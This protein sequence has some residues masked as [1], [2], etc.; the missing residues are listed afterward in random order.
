[1]EK[2]LNSKNPLY[3]LYF[4]DGEVDEGENGLIWKDILKEGEWAYRPVGGKA[5]P[6]PL[7]VVA[8][9]ASD[10]EI[11]FSDVIAAFEDEAIQHV[12]I[13]T[14]HSDLPHENTGYVRKLRLKERNGVKFLQ[15]ALEFTEPEIKEKAL[16]GSIANTSSGLLFD[17]VK[18][19]TGKKYKIAL[20]HVAL[21]NKPWLN[22][23]QPF[24]V[25]A[26]ENFS[27]EDHETL[28]LENVIWDSAKSLTS[29]RDKVQSTINKERKEN[30]PYVYVA[31]ITQNKA[32][33]SDELSRN[34]YVVSFQIRKDGVKVQE[35]TKWTKASKEWVKASLSE[36]VRYFNSNKTNFDSNELS[37]EAPNRGA[38]VSDPEQTGGKLMGLE[39]DNKEDTPSAPSENSAQV[40][41]L[42]D[43]AKAEL[44][45]QFRSELSEAVKVEKDENDKLRAKVHVMEVD[46]KVAV[47]SEQGFKEHPGLLAEIR[48]VMLADA[49]SSSLKLSETDDKGNTTE[50]ELS[51]TDAV[52]RI[53]NKLPRKDDKVSLSDQL[54]EVEDH[55]K[56]D[57]EVTLSDDERANKLEEELGIDTGKRTKKE[58]GDA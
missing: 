4:T 55:S 53:L 9:E 30:D 39:K 26:S 29:L 15:A 13:P 38:N 32:L 57:S 34:N 10:K 16:R 20:G 48:N 50:V 5:V 44:Q 42:S 22:G 17:Y 49:G 11:G 21:T 46:K 1:M 37:E 6:E 28:M 7:K 51:V 47:L 56:P 8:G 18:K 14:S 45:E 12:T 24:G 54:I 2:D 33:V 52:E 25:A 43:E 3:E 35:R 41:T 31:D 58:E 19:D 36:E 27:D 23:M 40:I